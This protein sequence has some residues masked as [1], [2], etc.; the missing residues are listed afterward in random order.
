MST[1]NNP[2]AYDCYANADPDEEMFVLL[3]RD[4]MGP[5][6]V[7]LWAAVREGNGEDPAKVAEARG[8]AE[9]MRAQSTAAGKTEI[10]VSD[11]FSA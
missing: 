1:K 10:D 9:R 4:R 6:L 5:S 2:G 11:Y 8:V 7:E 3:A